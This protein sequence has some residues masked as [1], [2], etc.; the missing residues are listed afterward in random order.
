MFVYWSFQE[1]SVEYED[2]MT[3]VHGQTDGHTI[4]REQSYL[5]LKFNSNN[6]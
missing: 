1:N 4:F 3:E 6:A 2:N 5:K